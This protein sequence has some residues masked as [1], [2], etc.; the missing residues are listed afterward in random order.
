M[1]TNDNKI[2]SPGTLSHALEMRHVSKSFPGTLAVNN[3]SFTV[4]PG[5]VHALVGENGAG[6]STLMKILA[7]SF[8]DY[9]GEI[10]IGGQ[11][12]S[13]HSPGAAKEYGIGM[14]YQELSL[15]RPI[16]VAE[17]LL[18]GRLPRKKGT[19]LVDRK[20]VERDAKALLE[21]VGLEN[22]DIHASISEI[23][24][25]EA[26]L[27]EIAKVLGGNPSVLVMDEPTSALSST[28]VA[29]LF[30]I[31][32]RLKSQGI[33]IAY[34]S[35]HLQ[36]IFE[37]ADTITVMRDGKHVRTCKAGEVNTEDV[38]KMMVGRSLGEFYSKR[39]VSIGEEAFRVENL[40]RYGFFHTI[41]FAVRSGEIL[42][43]CGLAGAGRTELA[44]S[45]I[46]VDPLDAGDIYINRQKVRIRNMGE[47]IDRGVAYLTESRK[48]DG[49]AIAL[50]V[51]ENSLAGIIPRLSRGP[52]YSSRKNRKTVFELID[53]LSIYPRDTEIPVR[54][55]SGGNQQKVLMAKW[56]AAAPKV[57]ILDEPTRGVDIGAKE[58]IHGA[59]AELAAR[60][61]AIILFTSDLPEMVGLCDRA[62]IMRQGHIIGEIDRK[63]MSEQSLLLAA[64]G[65]GE[66][67]A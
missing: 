65:E 64:N 54:N 6:K 51:G 34:I 11:P 29:R 61:N 47:A 23:S 36:E 5:E 8:S 49:L 56:I 4:S 67:V 17:N 22:L 16:S 38:V 57:M 30:D 21:R 58:I 66:F 52:L 44:R 37:I 31:I 40:S 39:E 24:Q 59:I 35:H 55:L 53:K 20:A 9:T 63:N 48:V 41:N 2:E 33:A 18:A 26:Q 14:V 62:V 28:E 1:N 7:G 25:C 10:L 60:G 46:G 32:R 15:A 19:P 12:V 3:V 43:I 50:T 13:L 27:V 45:I 42:G